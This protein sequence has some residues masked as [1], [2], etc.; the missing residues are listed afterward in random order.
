MCIYRAIQTIVGTLTL[1]R[2][3]KEGQG[4]AKTKL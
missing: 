1:N 2:T 4:K 3:D